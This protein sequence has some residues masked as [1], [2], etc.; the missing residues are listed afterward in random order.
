MNNVLLVYNTYEY[1]MTKAYIDGA[2]A[3]RE[4][5]SYH[6]NPYRSDSQYYMDWDNGHTHESAC[7]HFIDGEDILSLDKTGIIFHW[8]EDP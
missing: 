7:M 8:P 2:L 4:G 5:K 6:M 3:M 1:Q